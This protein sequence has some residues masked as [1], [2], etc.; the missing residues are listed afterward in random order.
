MCSREEVVLR[1]I[2]TANQSC[3]TMIKMLA[4]R[5][6]KNA[7]GFWS[8][9]HRLIMILVIALLSDAFSTFLRLEKGAEDI[10]PLV[11]Y[12]SDP[13]ILG[14]LLSPLVVAVL[15]GGAA[16]FV[17]IYWRRFALC[18]LHAVTIISF[19]A[20]WYNLWGHELYEPRLLRWFF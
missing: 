18:I 16:I 20:A 5:L 14:Y 8:V 3:Q 13:A 15:K 12:L 19:W 4:Q 2:S 1:D 10:H 6:K 17:A 9:Y 11:R 7:Q